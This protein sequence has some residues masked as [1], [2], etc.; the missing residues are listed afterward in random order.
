MHDENQRTGENKRNGVLR[1]K[2]KTNGKIMDHKF[3][4]L[5][6]SLAQSVT[7]RAAL[8]KFGVGLACM[9]LTCFGLANRA[10]SAP[11]HSG[12][13]CTSDADCGS[14]SY[15]RSGTCVPNWCAAGDG[16][17]CYPIKPNHCGTALPPCA[18]N[19]DTCSII[20][21]DSLGCTHRPRF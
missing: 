14:K 5:T 20:C 7:R 10:N 9:A 6:K 21:N 15:C 3:D 11:N 13:G 2:P 4:E 8:K 17:C 16:C 18:P 1:A 12:C 19:Y